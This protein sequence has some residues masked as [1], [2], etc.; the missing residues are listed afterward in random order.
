VQQ[1]ARRMNSLWGLAPIAAVLLAFLFSRWR[2]RRHEQRLMDQP[3]PEQWQQILR[4]HLPVY[5]VLDL[6]ER[7]TL[8][9]L[10][11]R[12]IDEK[13]FYGCAGLVVTDRMKLCIAAESC[14]LLLGQ[15]GPIYPTLQSILVYPTGFI[16]RR[17]VH[18]EDGIVAAGEH[19][20]LGESWSNGSVILSWDSVEEGARDFSDGHN[21]VLH[22]FAHQLDSASGSVNGAPPLR[23][24]SY[25]TWARV[26]SDSF[27]DLRARVEHGKQTI[28]DPYGA[29]N[30]AEFFAVATETFFEKPEDLFARRPRLFEELRQYYRVDPREW[31][32]RLARGQ[33]LESPGA[34]R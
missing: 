31:H 25:Q 24:N 3:F 6:Q 1:Q 18:Q 11:K 19:H 7:T 28:M 13:K 20:L 30:P 23:T 22:E 34:S 12:F 4:G 29:S 15:S 5:T 9:S 10:I 32:R 14:L 16:A 21:L 27:D 33:S 26:F 8:E 2:R 17:D